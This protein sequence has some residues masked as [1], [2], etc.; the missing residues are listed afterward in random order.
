MHARKWTII[1]ISALVMASM[2]LVMATAG[3]P[4]R[5]AS[6]Q[7][8]GTVLFGSWD[9][10]NGNLRHLASIEDFNA[11]YPDIEVEILPN[12]AG[13]DWHTKILTW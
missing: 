9:D 11:V 2:L 8:T 10:E 6:A 5:K 3:L 13:S 4:S 12:P 7:A 1:Y